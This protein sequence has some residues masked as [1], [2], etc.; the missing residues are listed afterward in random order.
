[1]RTAS[2]FKLFKWD[3]VVKVNDNLKSQVNRRHTVVLATK[4]NIIMK[5]SL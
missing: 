2:D 4:P 1:V 5:E 3:K